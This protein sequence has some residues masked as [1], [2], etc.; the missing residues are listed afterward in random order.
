MSASILMADE[1]G[2]RVLTID[3]AQRSNA[4]DDE[5]SQ[6]LVEHFTEANADPDVRVVV[7]TGSGDRAF[8]AGRDLRELD[9]KA[10][11]QTQIKQPMVA[12]ERNLH[13]TVFETYKP[14][15]A[16]VNG[17][18]VGGGCELALAC[19]LRIAA[20]HSFLQLSEAKRGMGANF[21]SVLLPQLLPRAIAMEML[22]CGRRMLPDE[23]LQWGLLNAVH[24]KERLMDEAMTFAHSI[25]RNAP[26]SLRRYAEMAKK[27]WGQPISAG[28]RLNVGPNPYTSKDRVEGVNAFVEKREPHWTGE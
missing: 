28:L 4:L 8:C 1:G 11:S 12:A 21:A 22:Y 6:L 18:A 19:D 24:P 3:R 15:L 10:K 2:V 14:V 27:S 13:E 25:A 5:A 26:L 17:A 20:E 7:V 16:V 9:D 23:A